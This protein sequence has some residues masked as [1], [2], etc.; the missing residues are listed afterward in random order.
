MPGEVVIKWEKCIEYPTEVYPTYTMYFHHYLLLLLLVKDAYKQYF[1]WVNF[2]R[3]DE[4]EETLPMCQS[5]CENFFRV[6]GFDEDLWMCKNIIDNEF[7]IESKSID[8]KLSYFPGEPFKKNEY[9]AKKRSSIPKE[10][11]TPSIKGSASQ[12]SLLFVVS[13]ITVMVGLQILLL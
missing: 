11:C 2:P 8:T 6:C 1:C 3:C 13:F 12:L 5:V 4:F 10:V 9:E 7:D